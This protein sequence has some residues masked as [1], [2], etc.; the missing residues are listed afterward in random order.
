MSFANCS[1]MLCP[2]SMLKDI[3]SRELINLNNLCCMLRSDWWGQRGIG[4]DFVFNESPAKIWAY[5]IEVMKL[6]LR[7][8]LKQSIDDRFTDVLYR[9][10]VF[11]PFTPD[12]VDFFVESCPNQF[13]PI[14]E[15]FFYKEKYRKYLEKEEPSVVRWFDE[16]QYQQYKEKR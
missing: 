16:E 3:S 8:G 12:E 14:T 9:G 1:E 10:E 7:K 5:H 13:F 4:F 6:L 11:E 2:Q 15:L